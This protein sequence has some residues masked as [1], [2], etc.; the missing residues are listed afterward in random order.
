MV[1]LNNIVI[2]ACNEGGHFAQLM[3]LKE[4]FSKYDSVILTD[5]KRANKGI[6]SLKSD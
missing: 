6:P 1:K 4:L 3:A 5:N 2:F